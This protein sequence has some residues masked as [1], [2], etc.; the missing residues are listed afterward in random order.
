M[1]SRKV[2]NSNWRKQLAKDMDLPSAS[3]EESEE[4][5][6]VAR[7]QAHQREA[8]KQRLR[9]KLQMILGKLDRPSGALHEV[10]RSGATWK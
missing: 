5:D 7:R 3:D 9:A 6:D 10:A 4:D 2:S 8:E 1:E